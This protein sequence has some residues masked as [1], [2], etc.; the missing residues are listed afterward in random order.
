MSNHK[1]RNGIGLALLYV[2]GFVLLL[3]TSPQRL[4]IIVL[5]VPFLYV[6]GTVFLTVVYIGSLLGRKRGVRLL[7]TVI[8]IFVV[9]IFVL[10][11]MHQ[12][13]SKD[14]LISLF[15]TVL[16]GWYIIKLRG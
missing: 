4:P 6:F 7:A 13:D 14:I 10:G 1:I 9:L 12:L 11:S 5:I 3:F 16:L 8:S 2:L 15:I